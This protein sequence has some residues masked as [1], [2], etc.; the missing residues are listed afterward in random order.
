MFRHCKYYVS[1]KNYSVFTYLKSFVNVCSRLKMDKQ[2]LFW[3]LDIT[4]I[5]LYDKTF[6]LFISYNQK[7][8]I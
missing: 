1:T 3:R 2:P 4:Y 5:C 6:K 7:N 8:K